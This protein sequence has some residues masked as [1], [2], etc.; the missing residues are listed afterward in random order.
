[1]KRLFFYIVVAAGLAGCTKVLDKEDKTGLGDET[2]DNES[3][4]TLFLNR[5]Y[6]VMMPAWPANSGTTTLPNFNH[7]TNDESNTTGN[8]AL[9]G[10]TLGN[11]AIVD[12]GSVSG[13][14]ALAYVNIRRVNILLKEIDKGSLAQDIRTKIKAQAYFLRAWNYFHLVKTYGGVPYITNPQ[15]WVGE[16]VYTPRNKTSECIDSLMRDLDSAAL[17]RPNW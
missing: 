5:C 10:G 16:D 17:A 3:T 4:A 8:T 2:W 7:Y 13:S 6:A 9:L 11:D 1:M 14:G 15:D 12:F